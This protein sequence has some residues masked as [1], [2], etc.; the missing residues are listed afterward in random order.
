MVERQFGKEQFL[1]RYHSAM[2]KIPLVY[3]PKE[4]VQR[5]KIYSGGSVDI[6]DADQSDGWRPGSL[7][8]SSYL[9]SGFYSNETSFQQAIIEDH[10]NEF[11]AATFVAED[12]QNKGLIVST[13]RLLRPNNENKFLFQKTYTEITVPEEPIYTVPTLDEWKRACVEISGFAS[14][15]GAILNGNKVPSLGIIINIINWARRRKDIQWGVAA[16]DKSFY[17][18]L[19]MLGFSFDVI[20]EPKM[21]R[22]SVTVPVFWNF[23]SLVENLKHNKKALIPGMADLINQRIDQDSFSIGVCDLN[24]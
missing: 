20:A 11:V 14:T 9:A 2:E 1:E 12:A 15:P 7:R 16:I 4:D 18:R 6:R 17:E 10:W 22:G 24:G 3:L 21:D 23:D 8:Y 5:R 13:A 19:T